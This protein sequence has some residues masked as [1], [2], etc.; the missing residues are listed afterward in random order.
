MFFIQ[1]RQ[2]FDLNEKFEKYYDCL[3]DKKSLLFETSST[4]VPCLLVYGDKIEVIDTVSVKEG[5]DIH[6]N[7]KKLKDKK[8][9]KSLMNEFD[10]KLNQTFKTSRFEKFLCFENENWWRQFKPTHPTVIYSYYDITTWD[11]EKMVTFWVHYLDLY[12]NKNEIKN[13]AALVCS[14]TVGKKLVDVF[15]L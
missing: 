3:I 6:L 2:K 7:L 8:L 14:V 9:K 13:D 11:E 15:L 1:K 4:S 5:I 10:K 12:L